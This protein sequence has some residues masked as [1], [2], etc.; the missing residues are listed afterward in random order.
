MLP[1]FSIKLP[2]STTKDKEV[3]VS[4][5]KPIIT[6]EGKNI[7]WIYLDLILCDCEE[8]MVNNCEDKQNQLWLSHFL[9]SRPRHA[10]PQQTVHFSAFPN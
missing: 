2:Q 5:N 8:W 4:A 7:N 6:E 10:P 9:F 1:T 3:T